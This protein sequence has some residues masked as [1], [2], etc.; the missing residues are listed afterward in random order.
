MK[1]TLF[2]VITGDIVHST[3]IPAEERNKL[4]RKLSSLRKNLVEAGLPVLQSEVVR[5]DSFQVLLKDPEDSIRALFMLRAFFRS[6]AIPGFGV[7]E[8]RMG[9]GIGPIEFRTRRL[10]A[11]DGTA[12]RLAA[13]ALEALDNPGLA[14]WGCMTESAEFNRRLSALLIACEPIAANWTAVQ[15]RAVWWALQGLTHLEIA[16]KTGV[17]QSTVSRT[18]KSANGQTVRYICNH[19]RTELMAYL[20]TIAQP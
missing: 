1:Q 12:F 16:E 2:G 4:V 5:G 20:E 13:R 19:A 9:L 18:L 7:L 8:A 6:S 11:S 15:A 17:N 3:R 14:L 10:N